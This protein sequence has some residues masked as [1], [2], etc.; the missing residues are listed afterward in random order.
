MSIASTDFERTD[1]SQFES[2]PQLSHYYNDIFDILSTTTNAYI[3]GGFMAHWWSPDPEKCKTKDIDIFF[4]NANDVDKIRN[5]LIELNWIKCD[6]SPTL[7]EDWENPKFEWKVQLILGAFYKD[8][9]HII[10]G[11][12]LRCCQIAY[13]GC[14]LYTH[15]E[16]LLDVDRKIINIHRI[17]DLTRT[18]KHVLR[19]MEK[20]FNLST[21]AFK[22]I[23]KMEKPE[24]L[25]SSIVKI[26]TGLE[27]YTIKGIVK[28]IIKQI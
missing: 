25:R 18:K 10:D 26:E 13:D 7:C 1:L 20:G 15:K 22:T 19:Y 4:T 5:K 9:Y 28:R 2:K 11:F 27:K 8:A 24:R 21:E 14:V 3:A 23:L 6:E 16:A 12:D 17:R